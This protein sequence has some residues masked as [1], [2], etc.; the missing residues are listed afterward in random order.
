[1]ILERTAIPGAPRRGRGRRPIEE[2]RA[3]VMELVSRVMIDEGLGALTVE[4]VS[5]ES[6]VSRTTIYK[7]WPSVGALALDGFF[8]AVEPQLA[9][10]D[11]GD[12]RA[13]LT[14]QLHHFVE[15]MTATPAGR[16]LREL[17]GR[18][19]TDPELSAEFRRLYSSER[20]RLAVSRLRAAQ[21]AGQLRADL[22]LESVVDQLWGAVYNRL[23]TPD[24]PVTELFTDTLV[25][26]LF[27]GIA[28]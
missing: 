17:V 23:L 1:M 15:V 2:V 6:G 18:A 4:R 20:R 16:I 9:F 21:E 26:N 25:D 19:Q 12:I 27:R 10:P 3:D 5:R 13:D 11:T 7:V 14:V 28:A 22:D 24:Q 8:H